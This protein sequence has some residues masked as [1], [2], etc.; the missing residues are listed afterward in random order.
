ME[1]TNKIAEFDDPF[2][3]KLIQNA[4]NEPEIT[5]ELC[6][7][8]I[9]HYGTKITTGPSHK[10]KTEFHCHHCDRK[11]IMTLEQDIDGKN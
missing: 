5:E 9:Y 4:D 6:E 2:W 1:Y 8:G 7:R 11:L 3:N 10:R